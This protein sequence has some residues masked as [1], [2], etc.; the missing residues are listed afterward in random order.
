[1][2]APTIGFLR[3]SAPGPAIAQE[4]SL[5]VPSVVVHAIDVRAESAQT[6]RRGAGLIL[7][8]LTLLAALH[9]DWTTVAGFVALESIGA[10]FVTLREIARFKRRLETLEPLPSEAV[11]VA[12]RWKQ[13]R[14]EPTT[15]R[16]TLGSLAVLGGLAVANV[17]FFL[18]E[19]RVWAERLTAITAAGIALESVV[20]PLVERVLVARW[21]RA[22]PHARLFRLRENDPDDEDQRQLYV[23]SGPLVAE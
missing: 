21:E 14:Q 20:R 1:M 12:P 22:H 13:P 15:L 18:D 7:V 3:R 23:S 4:A 2:K 10:T 19:K 6:S 9:P 11:E 8:L 17:F 5:S 16:Q